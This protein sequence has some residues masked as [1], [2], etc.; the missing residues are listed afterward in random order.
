MEADSPRDGARAFLF[1][2]KRVERG[3]VGINLPPV[4]NYLTIAN[5]GLHLIHKQANLTGRLLL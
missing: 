2:K 4:I 3:G 5:V 1:L